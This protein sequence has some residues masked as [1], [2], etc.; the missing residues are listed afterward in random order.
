MLHRDS[1]A[2]DTKRPPDRTPTNVDSR[3][4][5]VKANSSIWR[6]VAFPMFILATLAVGNVA[7][8]ASF[9]STR[10]LGS[11]AAATLVVPIVNLLAAGVGLA[12]IP[13]AR[14]MLRPSSLKPHVWSAVAG[15][16]LA[17]GVDIAYIRSLP[18]GH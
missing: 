2:P 7:L 11:G 4:T 10:N 8:V 13:L 14:R 12:L 16:V 5:S 3:A 1:N 15:A 18:L 17:I 6:N 9:G